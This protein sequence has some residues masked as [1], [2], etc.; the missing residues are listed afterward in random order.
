M[1]DPAAS[2]E[3][4]HAD[5]VAFW[6]GEGGALWLDR[7]ARIESRLKPLG[8]HALRAAAARP[9]ERAIDIGCGLGHTTL[10]LARSVGPTGHVLGAD[11]SPDMIAEASRRAASAGL[12]H[13][14]FAAADASTHDFGPEAADL[15]FSRFGVMFF[16]HP[17]AA[18]ANLR[19]GLKPGGRV[20]LLVWRP[21]KENG[22][23]F[24][25]FMAAIPHLP[26]MPRPNQ[27]DPGP[28]SLSDPDRARRVLGAAGFVD[29][30]LDRVDDTMS[31]SDGP[32]EDAVRT[33]IDMGPLARPLRQADEATRARVAD[34]IQSA[35]AKHLTAEGV[36]LPAAC[37]LLTAR[38]RG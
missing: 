2:P 21:V 9:G 13:A 33:A 7:D 34:A 16:G 6:R 11:L 30:N 19:R 5:Q 26:P 4:L 15:L 20:T 38:N 32:L 18:F 14:R 29:V 22:W 24:V 28:F 12:A 37:W 10:A 31:L 1:S 36:R 25:P 17:E 35:L 8:E 23:M 3:K 27:G